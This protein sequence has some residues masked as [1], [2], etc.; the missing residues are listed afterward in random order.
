MGE[1]G[2]MEEA[3]SALTDD[4]GDDDYD[5]LDFDERAMRSG[6]YRAPIGARC[7]DRLCFKKDFAAKELELWW[8]SKD[9]AALRPRRVMRQGKRFTRELAEVNRKRV[10]AVRSGARHQPHSLEGLLHAGVA[11]YRGADYRW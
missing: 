7:C 9:A 4:V 10:V 11:D 2:F 3:P 1:D 5:E 8:A 6:W